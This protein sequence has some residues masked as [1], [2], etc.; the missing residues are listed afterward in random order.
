MP[1]N[2]FQDT[3]SHGFI[4]NII[5]KG[6]LMK[7][8]DGGK[9]NVIS[10][11]KVSYYKLWPFFSHIFEIYFVAWCEVVYKMSRKSCEQGILNI[12]FQH[13]LIVFLKL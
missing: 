8:P 11:T 9:D 12:F 7:G 3:I 2:Y 5:K 4:S 1:Q 6:W 13:D 10:F